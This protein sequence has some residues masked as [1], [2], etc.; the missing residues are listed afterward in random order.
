MGWF[1]LLR[2][3]VLH[4]DAALGHALLAAAALPL[5]ASIVRTPE[6][7]LSAGEVVDYAALMADLGQA[8]AAESLLTALTS[9]G[10]SRR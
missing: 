7:D 5:A 2:D 1:D 6:G 9:S 10:G 4:G 3:A 8:A